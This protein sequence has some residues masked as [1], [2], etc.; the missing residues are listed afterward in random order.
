MNNISKIYWKNENGISLIIK[1]HEKRFENH[2][3]SKS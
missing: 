3:F 1:T 2:K